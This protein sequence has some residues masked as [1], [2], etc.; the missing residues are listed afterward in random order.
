[1]ELYSGVIAG[2]NLTYLS[3]WIGFKNGSNSY[4]GRSVIIVY[5]KDGRSINFTAKM[6]YDK[7][8]NKSVVFST[9]FRILSAKVVCWL[10]SLNITPTVSI[11]DQ[12]NE[13]QRFGLKTKMFLSKDVEIENHSR[14]TYRLEDGRYSTTYTIVLKLTHDHKFWIA[15]HNSIKDLKYESISDAV[16]ECA[17]IL[18]SKCD[19]S[20]HEHIANMFN[21]SSPVPMLLSSSSEV[22]DSPDRCEH[23][24]PIIFDANPEDNSLF[25]HNF[26]I[27]AC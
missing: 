1:M 15:S 8:T 23:K 7:H 11:D 17:N 2:Y 13:I 21:L 10:Y 5:L 3:K 16:Q 22:T 27:K 19:L 4:L 24:S 12:H 9:L 14:Y 26:A 20:K 25:E 6:E 18:K